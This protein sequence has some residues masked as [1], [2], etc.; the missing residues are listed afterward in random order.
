MAGGPP[1]LLGLRDAAMAGPGPAGP[2]P[3]WATNKLG[4]TAVRP[5]RGAG[6]GERGAGRTP[7]GLSGG[8]GVA[9]LGAGGAGGPAAVRAVR[10]RAAA[11]GAGVLPAGARPRAPR[12]PR[13]RLRRAA[14]LGS[15]PQVSAG[16]RVASLPLL[17]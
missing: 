13:V 9:G 8:V 4:G 15:R 3:A 16:P 10:A 2:L 14:L 11:A 5:G 1:V 17:P 7:A 6:C 12:A